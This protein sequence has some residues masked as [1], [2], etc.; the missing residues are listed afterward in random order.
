[1]DK[2]QIAHWR[3]QFKKVEG[4]LLEFTDPWANGVCSGS[5][6]ANFIYGKSHLL[7]AG[8]TEILYGPYK[9]GKSLF[10]HM[11]AGQ[12]HQED[13]DAI[14]VKFDTEMR[15]ELQ[16]TPQI[17]KTF[18]IDWNRLFVVQTDNPALVF[19]QIEGKFQAMVQEGCPIKYIIIDSMDGIRGRRS[20]NANSVDVQQRGDKAATIQEGISR[21]MPVQRKH[22]IAI[23]AIA[24]LRSEQDPVEQMRH[25]T[26]KMSGAFALKHWAEFFIYLESNQSKDGKK[27]ELGHE[28][29]DNSVSDLKKNGEQLGHKIRITMKESSAGP[30]GRTGEFTFD[31]NRGLINVHEEVFRLGLSRNIIAHPNNKVY[32]FGGKDWNGKESFLMA[33]KGDEGMQKEI[34]KELKMQDLEGKFAASDAAAA[35]ESAP[36]VDALVADFG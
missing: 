21:I 31:Y 16:L 20:L 12:L 26:T 34:I 25:K 18:G 19:D 36:D 6:S 4:A 11:K 35:E 24:Q 9:G 33:L 8:Y 29:V 23:S 17:A 10:A 32:S 13:P 30:K 1:M 3:N 22:K 7:P 2:K 15:T 27:D 14:V 28:F 5:P